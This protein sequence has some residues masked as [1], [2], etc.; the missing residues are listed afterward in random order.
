[1]TQAATSAAAL[2]PL[3]H[4]SHSAGPYCSMR[5][6]RRSNLTLGKLPFGKFHIWEVATWEIVTWEVAL[7]KMPLY[8]T[9][10]IW[11]TNYAVEFELLYVY[12]N[13]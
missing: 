10:R 2:G 11:Q 6:L 13:L 7:G 12:A 1:M 5:C 8:L 4:V 3:S 9:P